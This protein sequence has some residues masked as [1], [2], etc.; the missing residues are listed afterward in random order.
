M[1]QCRLGVDRVL[2]IWYTWYA[3]LRKKRWFSQRA[4]S[5][6]AAAALAFME[7]GQEQQS[8]NGYV[9]NAPSEIWRL[10]VLGLGRLC[11]PCFGAYR[12][13]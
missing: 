2:L 9:M 6:Q 1:I 12:S 8:P 3:A 13:E 10:L 4:A 5:A 7:A 11:M